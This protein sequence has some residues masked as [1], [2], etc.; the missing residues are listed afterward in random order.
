MMGANTR[1]YWTIIIVAVTAV[2]V[3]SAG[4]T[5][6]TTQSPTPGVPAGFLS[7]TNTN[8]G[9]AMSY[10]SDWQLIGNP[11]GVTIAEFQHGND[12]ILFQIQLIGLNQSGS[13]PQN[14]APS[15]ISNLLESNDSVSLLE[16][17]TASFAGQPGYEI[18]FTLKTSGGEPYKG[19]MIWTVK[20]SSV[21]EVEFTGSA[22]QYDQEIGTA[23]QMISSFEL[24]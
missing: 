16:N 21:Y 20:G 19:L 2:A 18:V 10:P 24:T 12:T 22:T 11:G 8:A 1:M 6:Q 7:Y 9:V 14:L 13:T 17:H 5:S 4:C 15:L 3:S 23:Q